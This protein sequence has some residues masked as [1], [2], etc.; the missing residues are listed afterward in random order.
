MDNPANQTQLYRQDG[1]VTDLVRLQDRSANLA[2]GWLQGGWSDQDLPEMMTSGLLSIVLECVENVDQHSAAAPEWFK[3]VWDR[4]KAS[5]RR[6]ESASSA[7]STAIQP[8]LLLLPIVIGALL[9]EVFDGNLEAANGVK[10]VAPEFIETIITK[11]MELG[12]DCGGDLRELTDALDS[13]SS[14]LLPPAK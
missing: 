7:P 2:A 9:N 14:N 10:T 6:L 3:D 5:A 12:E 4:T 11:A 8:V 13:R 1:L